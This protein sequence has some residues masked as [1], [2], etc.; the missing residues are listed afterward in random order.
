MGLRLLTQETRENQSKKTDD[1]SAM[2][3]LEFGNNSL[4]S[5]SRLRSSQKSVSRTS[6]CINPT[7]IVRH[8]WSKIFV[9]KLDH[10]AP[11]SLSHPDLQCYDNNLA[12]A[13]KN[14]CVFIT[15]S[16]GIVIIE[17]KLNG[18]LSFCSIL[19]LF[20]FSV[21]LEPHVPIFFLEFVRF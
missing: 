12:H 13:I 17:H 18:L 8:D 1:V 4:V 3:Y 10:T 21:S 16:R 7:I 11:H 6:L 2:P 20:R 15:L 9:P 5:M 14:K 19:C